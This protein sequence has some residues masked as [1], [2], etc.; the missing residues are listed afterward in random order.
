[1]P[2]SV[3]N[4]KLRIHHLVQRS[5]QLDTALFNYRRRNSPEKF[6]EGYIQSA[7]DTLPGDD[8][9]YLEIGVYKGG[10]LRFIKASQ[11]IGVDPEPLIDLNRLATNEL[12]V[13]EESDHF[14]ASPEA[15]RL[16]S[17]GVSV[18]LVDG[19]H[20]FAQAWRDVVNVSRYMRAD[21]LI[22]LD[23]CNPLN[24]MAAEDVR[25]TANWNGD[26]W[27]VMALVRATQPQWRSLT[28]DADQGVGLIWG[29]QH[30][31]REVSDQ[32]L[33]EFKA[34]TYTDLQQD[35]AALIGLTVPRYLPHDAEFASPLAHD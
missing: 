16:L 21:G 4:L 29:F 22:V 24:E 2:K 33:S 11:K 32:N 35:R 13:V 14:F 12:V 3:D 28:V 27:K 18:A 34:M 25:N 10:S 8:H 15:S 26:V 30:S 31:V 6:K 9:L 19:L 1:M 20:E 5:P 23:D 17:D 7:L